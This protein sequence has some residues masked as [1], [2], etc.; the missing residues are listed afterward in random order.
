[1]FVDDKLLVRDNYEYL[2]ERL[3]LEESKNSRRY[4]KKTK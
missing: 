3:I 1:M 4:I 2:I